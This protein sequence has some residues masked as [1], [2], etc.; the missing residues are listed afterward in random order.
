MKSFSPVFIETFAL[1]YSHC[2]FVGPRNAKYL[3]QFT[4][5]PA[6][7]HRGIGGRNEEPFAIVETRTTI[8]Q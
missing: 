1:P 4:V 6:Y 5:E 8:N 3:K 7:N 2:T